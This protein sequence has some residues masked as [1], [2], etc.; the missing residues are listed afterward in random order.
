M[1]PLLDC[2]VANLTEE[3]A[4]QIYS[5]CGTGARST[6]RTLRH[7]LEVSEIVESELPGVPSAVWTTKLTQND[8][9][10]AY[11]ILSFSNATLVLSI[12]ETVEEVTDTGFLSSAPTLAVQQLGEDGLIQV[13]PKGIRHIRADR[14]VNEWTAPQHRSIVAA[15][16][17]SRQV[18]VA[19]SSGEIVYFEMDSDGSLAEYDEKREMSGTVTCLSLGEVPEGRVRSQFLAVGCDDSTVRILSLDPDSTLENKSVQ[20]LTSAPSALS[21]MAMADSSSGGSTL[22]LHIGLYSGVYLRTVLDEVTGELSDTRT[23]FL[24]PKPAKLFRVS[25]QGQSAVLALSSRPWLGYSDPVTK[26]FMLTPLNY[27]ALEWGWNFSSEQCTE[28]MVGIQGQNLRYVATTFF[29][30]SDSSY[31]MIFLSLN[32][33]MSNLTLRIKH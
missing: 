17:N 18:A 20:A 15:T 28:G 13:H 7:G 23:R 33:P 26:G 30:R 19:L 27:P 12:G 14:R 25:V 16:T 24:G 6:F 1:N 32:C 31:M 9:F 29:F 21:I 11:I 4:P 3:D 2:K 22:Y 5:I 10:D 8:T